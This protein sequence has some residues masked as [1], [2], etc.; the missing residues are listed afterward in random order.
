MTSISLIQ[1]RTIVCYD[2]LQG[3]NACDATTTHVYAAIN[4][5]VVF[6]WAV[7]R[8]FQR[9]ESEDNSLPARL[10]SRRSDW[11]DGALCNILRDKLNATTHEL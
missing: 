10:R 8:L 4:R 9:F 5:N 7:A 2:I 11:N 6:R 3:H 1:I